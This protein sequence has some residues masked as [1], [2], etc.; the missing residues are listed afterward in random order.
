MP[1]YVH[2]DL[3]EGEREREK[4]ATKTIEINYLHEK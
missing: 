4:K 1:H 2:K 3:I